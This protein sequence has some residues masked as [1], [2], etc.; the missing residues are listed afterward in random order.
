[1]PRI[2]SAVFVAALVCVV[3]GLLTTG[4]VAQQPYP[5]PPPPPGP[6]AHVEVSC[7]VDADR[8]ISCTG[9]GYLAD[10]QVTVEIRSVG[11][12]SGND[13]RVA[14]LVDVDEDGRISFTYQLGC[15]HDA[16]SV[17]IR[18]SG[19]DAND[20]PSTTTIRLDVPPPP[21][22]CS[23]QAAGE[24]P[25]ES[26][27]QGDQVARGDEAGRGDEDVQANRGRGGGQEA[28]GLQGRG[29]ERG[30]E[31]GV[32]DASA[33]GSDLM[34][35]VDRAPDGS[36]AL[37]GHNLLLLFATALVAAALVIV[38]VTARRQRRGAGNA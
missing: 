10:S 23:Q 26:D 28:R 8:E 38:P 27:V 34:A 35:A 19:R 36:P 16:P 9:E 21:D 5:P 33:G 4:A 13:P 11:R 31:G 32:R 20:R 7:E 30:N 12:G 15:R 2:R 17:R 1:M 24:Q 22:S 14:F 3:L 18:L 6:P 29:D 37:N 25:E